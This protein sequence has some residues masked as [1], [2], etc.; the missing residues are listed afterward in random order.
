MTSHS[1]TNATMGGVRPARGSLPPLTGQLAGEPLTT[2][3][4]QR[5]VDYALDYARRGWFVFPVHSVNTDGTCTCK[6]KAACERPG[7]HPAC[8]KG[9]KDATVDEKTIRGWW[10]KNRNY[11]IGLQAGPQSG[12]WV[13]DLDGKDAEAAIRALEEQHG[14]LP[15]TPKAKTG[16]GVHIYFCY[17][18]AFPVKN[19]AGEIASHIDT[20]GAGGYTILPPS[21]HYSGR[22]YQWVTGGSPADTPV[23]PPPDW[24]LE[25]LKNSRKPQPTQ[26][27]LPIA[28]AGDGP[29]IPEGRRNDTLF[30]MACHLREGGL[31]QEIAVNCLTSVN[32][33]R[34]EKPVPEQEL[35]GLVASA[36]QRQKYESPQD[37]PVGKHFRPLPFVRRILDS[38]QVIHFGGTFY[39]WDQSLRFYQ[40]WPSKQ[41]NNLVTDWVGDEI[42]TRFHK[43][44]LEILADRT[45]K[46]SEALPPA[47]LLNI[48]NGIFDVETGAVTDHD[49]DLIFL[50][51][52]PVIWDP[53]ARS[54]RYDNFI[55]QALPDAEQ[56]RLWEEI[57][58]YSLTRDCRYQTGTLLTDE[59]NI[60]TGNT[61]KSTCAEIVARMLGPQACSRLPLADLS[62]RFSV[63][64]MI[65]KHINISSE[66]DVKTYLT[67]S[68]IKQLISGEPVKAEVKYQDPIILVPT[69]KLI[70][71]SNSFPRSR[72]FGDAF[73][74]RWKILVFRHRFPKPGEPGNIPNFWD[75]FSQGDM[76]YVFLS[77]VGGLLRL[78]DTQQ[79]SCPE[80]SEK[81]LQDYKAEMNPVIDFTTECIEQAPGYEGD[82]LNKVYGVYTTWC[83]DTGHTPM[84]RGKKFTQAIERQI[85]FKAHQKPNGKVKCF[86]SVRAVWAPEK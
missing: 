24:L 36:F 25:L 22:Q 5:M 79:F 30:K 23:A 50:S 56:R 45:D 75:T 15:D 46:K 43:E 18:P 27:R 59:D 10:S 35:R 7:K 31:D 80:S 37:L 33:A 38:E 64:Q 74:R 6:K 71:T 9:L 13:L 72:D 65:G 54:E 20:R 1:G 41:I 40:E 83:G 32:E 26:N 62:A 73:F 63:A 34:W 53:D 67:D 69:A 12:V 21:R 81:A 47:N 48:Q 3:P 66:S 85:G 77:A 14:S 49:P 17:N 11:N 70:V 52:L 19:T 68:F 55:C 4:T 2:P 44:I 78:K 60:E 29:P 28:T 57:C 61:G 8:G 58:G 39:R 51:Q 82:T 42:R 16:R 76:N 86:P 84:S